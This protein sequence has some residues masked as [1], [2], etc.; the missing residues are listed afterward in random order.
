MPEDNQKKG[1][2]PR[3]PDFSQHHRALGFALSYA[4]PKTA[5]LAEAFKHLG[6]LGTTFS[7][8]AER[9][10]QRQ[11]REQQ[12]LRLEQRHGAAMQEHAQRMQVYEQDQQQRES[13]AQIR[14]AIMELSAGGQPVVP[15]APA[16]GPPALQYPPAGAAGPP[17][18]VPPASAGQEAA[19][20]QPP[21]PTL[22]PEVAAGASP[23]A[24]Q[25][26]MEVFGPGAAQARERAALKSQI[27][28]ENALLLGEQRRA[29]IQDEYRQAEMDLQE[30]QR[31]EIQRRQELREFEARSPEGIREF[32]DN[33]GKSLG[34]ALSRSP[35]RAAENLVRTLGVGDKAPDRVQRRRDILYRVLSDER[36]A[37]PVLRGDLDA[38]V[39]LTHGDG[40]IEYWLP[41]K[42]QESLTPLYIGIDKPGG[43]NLNLPDGTSV[44]FEPQG[45]SRMRLTKQLKYASPSAIVNQYQEGQEVNFEDLLGPSASLAKKIG[46]QRA[47]G[48]QVDE[49]TQRTV[50]NLNAQQSTLVNWGAD[51]WEKRIRNGTVT[52]PG[53]TSSVQT[54]F[55]EWVKSSGVRK[56]RKVWRDRSTNLGHGGMFIGV[57]EGWDPESVKQVMSDLHH[58]I[59]SR[60]DVQELEKKLREH[61]KD[62]DLSTEEKQGLLDES[63]RDWIFPTNPRMPS[64]GEIYIKG[65]MG[66]LDA[67]IAEHV[68][69]VAE[70]RTKRHAEIGPEPSFRRA[71]ER[72]LPENPPDYG[73]LEET[74]PRFVWL[75]K[76]ASNPDVLESYSMQVPGIPGSYGSDVFGGVGDFQQ[77]WNESKLP[78]PFTWKPE[79]VG[80]DDRMAAQFAMG[81]VVQLL[82]A[83]NTS[84]GGK[85]DPYAI[86]G[87]FM[88]RTPFDGAVKDDKT[89]MNSRSRILKEWLADEGLQAA[90]PKAF[91]LL[92]MLGVLYAPP[93][94]KPML[95]A[96]DNS[97]QDFSGIPGTSIQQPPTFPEQR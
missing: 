8:I 84:G 31:K 20:A 39:K 73:A 95:S 28:L 55:S 49:I 92:R 97:W 87:E 83:K 15:Q 52:M 23:S 22:S 4:R 65:A 61:L 14:R 79:D 19:P 40:R 1:F 53:A 68:K 45:S 5:N 11:F 16:Q 75:M 78:I 43:V 25:D 27:D 81:R 6:D 74:D 46:T 34:Y 50:S 7:D 77:T 88:K 76:Q 59:R 89:W 56:E 80:M 86:M 72:G 36:F 71:E 26:Y 38:G 90:N 58:A 93:T 10:E 51:F 21:S 91:P 48:L 13:D 96:P 85:I 2:A 3:A 12:A 41:T 70:Q 64:L 42:M 44:L 62:V 47:L 82:A 37:D 17:V 63:I 30:Y 24:F 35:S 18:S 57:N 67:A 29:E 54:P 69:K 60:E 94:L 33:S 32:L 66:D 9:R